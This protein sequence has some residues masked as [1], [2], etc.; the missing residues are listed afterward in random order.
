MTKQ[1]IALLL[2]VVQAGDR[3]TVGEADVELWFHV[4]GEVPLD[5]AKT[6]ALA[7]FRDRPGVW[8]EPGHIW[9]RWRDHRRDQL[10]RE[11]D[12]AREAR[13]AALDARLAGVDELAEAKAI[14]AD[15]AKVVIR[16]SL[17]GPNPLTVPC[18]W[19]RAGTGRPCTIPDTR[20]LTTNPHPS[21]VEAVQPKESNA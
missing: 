8:L 19:C 3:R 16:R 12:A 1:E 7:H 18:P 15:E 13:Q 21:R 20:Q 5:F 11:D 4:A 6:A 2:A 14:P 10:A 9:S 17:H